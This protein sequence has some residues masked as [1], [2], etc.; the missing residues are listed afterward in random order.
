MSRDLNSPTVLAFK[1]QLAASQFAGIDLH[2]PRDVKLHEAQRAGQSTPRAVRIRE[3][4]T[5][6][7][8]QSPSQLSDLLKAVVPVDDPVAQE[9][10]GG[11]LL[12][13]EHVEHRA[14]ARDMIKLGALDEFS[15]HENVLAFVPDECFDTSTAKECSDMISSNIMFMDS[16]PEQEDLASFNAARRGTVKPRPIYRGV[17]TDDWPALPQ[18]CSSFHVV[19]DLLAALLKEAKGLS[20]RAISDTIDLME[21]VY[22]IAAYPTAKEMSVLFGSES[23]FGKDGDCPLFGYIDRLATHSYVI[24]HPSSSAPGYVAAPVTKNGESAM[25]NSALIATLMQHYKFMKELSPMQYE[26]ALQLKTRTCENVV[27]MQYRRVWTVIHQSVI[28]T[29]WAC[30]YLLM[31]EKF[32]EEVPDERLGIAQVIEKRSDLEELYDDFPEVAHAMDVL[33]NEDVS[34]TDEDDSQSLSD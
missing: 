18:G 7:T 30:T 15:L 27:R 26:H 19:H 14:H 12:N 8:C 11:G 5:E 1:A 9:V 10:W 29:P 23:P 4:T 22:E 33:M 21:A 25:T 34:D 2:E 17:L 3:A 31:K 13:F 28:S 16:H 20:L 32:F 6:G 24:A